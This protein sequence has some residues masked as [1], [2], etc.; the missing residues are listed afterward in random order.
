MK[1]KNSDKILLHCCEFHA[2]LPPSFMHTFVDISTIM[3]I[4]FLLFVRFTHLND[5]FYL[6]DVH[7]VS[8]TKLKCFCVGGKQKWERT[9]RFILDCYESELERDFSFCKI[10][11]FRYLKPFP[12]S[13]SCLS[14]TFAVLRI[15]IILLCFLNLLRL[16]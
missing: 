1:R 5:F 14:K 4:Y 7:G 15:S 13:S 12:L 11:F 8:H 10:F 16:E 2:R 6:R 3:N 9:K